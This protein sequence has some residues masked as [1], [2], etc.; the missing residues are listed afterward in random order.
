MEGDD[1]FGGQ[2][3]KAVEAFDRQGYEKER[4]PQDPAQLQHDQ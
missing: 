3:Q 2:L 4:Y 1:F